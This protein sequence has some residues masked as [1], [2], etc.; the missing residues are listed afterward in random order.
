MF[1]LFRLLPKLS[2][3]ARRQ[4]STDMFPRGGMFSMFKISTKFSFRAKSDTWHFQN[5]QDVQAVQ[6]FAQSFSPEEK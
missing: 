5:V 2:H 1:R 3:W 6:A 4:Q